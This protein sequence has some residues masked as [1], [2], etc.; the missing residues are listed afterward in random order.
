MNDAVGFDSGGFGGCGDLQG[1]RS[2]SGDPIKVFGE[3]A[4]DHNPAFS[5][6]CPTYLGTGLLQKSSLLLSRTLKKG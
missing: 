4:G 5:Q 6:V 3:K 1:F 2:K